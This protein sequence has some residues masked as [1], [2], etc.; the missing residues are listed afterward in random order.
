MPPLPILLSTQLEALWVGES[1][2]VIL[3]PVHSSCC[4][5]VLPS[6]WS[7]LRLRH[8]WSVLSTLQGDWGRMKKE[9]WSSPTGL[10][11]E[12][13]DGERSQLGEACGY[14]FLAELRICVGCNSGGLPGGE[15][16]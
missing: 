14:D 5:S 3:T 6:T 1:L 7:S 10:L 4:S 2:G 15:G 9:P 11:L 8:L 13:P 16:P 12:R